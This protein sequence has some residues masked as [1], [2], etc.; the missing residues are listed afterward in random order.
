M[1]KNTVKIFVNGKV[2][3]DN[4]KNDRIVHDKGTIAMGINYSEAKFTNIK[5]TVKEPP[6][7]EKAK[8]KNAEKKNNAAGFGSATVGSVEGV[9]EGE[10]EE[11]EE[12]QDPLD[13]PE[14]DVEKNLDDQKEAIL[15]Y[16]CLRNDSLATRL[17]WCVDEMGLSGANAT[18]CSK[19]FCNMCCT[20]LSKELN[21]CNSK[22]HAATKPTD[23]DPTIIEKCGKQL[24]GDNFKVKMQGCKT[25]CTENVNE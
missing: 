23:M 17:K 3:F 15:D 22:C 9:E 21:V 6:K 24:D 25:C 2:L 18:T 11:E 8:V 5:L 12:E 4:I 14:V 20:T 10:E 16:K 13:L 7:E 19:S 1:I